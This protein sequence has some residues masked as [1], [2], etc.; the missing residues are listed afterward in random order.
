MILRDAFRDFRIGWRLLAKEPGYSAVVVLGLAVGFAACF[1]LLGYVRYCFSY[2]SH[3]PD[4]GR[5]VLVKQ[6]I[7][8]FPRPEWEV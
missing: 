6:R 3:V 4:A 2:N 1:L 5:V 8:W 7:N